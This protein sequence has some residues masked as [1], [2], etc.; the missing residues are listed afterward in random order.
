VVSSN[1]KNGAFIYADFTITVRDLP[2]INLVASTVHRGDFDNLINAWQALARWIEQNGYD[3][4]HPPS[5]EFY[6]SAPGDE[7][8]AEVQYMVKAKA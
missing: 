7:P 1:L 8:V 2:H 5:R 3:V 6:L 4:I